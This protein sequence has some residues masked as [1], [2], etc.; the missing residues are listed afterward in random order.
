MRIRPQVTSSTQQQMQLIA[1]DAVSGNKN[2]AQA[3]FNA[4]LIQASKGAKEAASESAQVGEFRNQILQDAL[5]GDVQEPLAQLQNLEENGNLETPSKA[6]DKSSKGVGNPGPQGGNPV[7]AESALGFFASANVFGQPSLFQP[8]GVAPI[9]GSQT[10]K[11]AGTGV[12]SQR[13]AVSSQGG[14]KAA[15]AVQASVSG[16]QSGMAPVQTALFTP[17]TAKM[18]TTAS[19]L[20]ESEFSPVN[21]QGP[22]KGSTS[23][24]T[25]GSSS[26]NATGKSGVSGPKASG[27]EE[28]SAPTQR[29]AGGSGT[30]AQ[31]SGEPE[32]G[33]GPVDLSELGLTVSSGATGTP[34]DTEGQVTLKGDGTWVLPEGASAAMKAAAG[35]GNQGISQSSGVSASNQGSNGP[36]APNSSPLSPSAWVASAQFPSGN[37]SGANGAQETVS[38]SVVEPSTEAIAAGVQV[39][40][41]QQQQS[42]G[43][44][45]SLARLS[46]NGATAQSRTVSQDEGDA[47]TQGAGVSAFSAALAGATQTN[48]DA[49]G[50]DRTALS[51][52][53]VQQVA[54]A[55][56]EAQASGTPGRLVIQLKPS[57][58]GSV[59]IDLSFT[60]GKLTAHVVAAQSDVRD[61]LVRDLSSLK[62]GLESHGVQVSEVSVALRTG[63]QDQQRQGSGAQQQQ[64]QWWRTATQVAAN[65]ANAAPAGSAYGAD[66]AGGSKN[67]SALA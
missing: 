53:V 55:L 23:T 35:I 47:R 64:P 25:A 2:N 10:S 27:Q 58:L 7:S 52:P 61:V 49:S 8:M 18:L 40:E 22:V 36:T 4:A 51:E 11:G 34:V 3:K 59:Q 50:N 13:T 41:Q 16:T 9:T 28:L 21:A 46:E 15:G 56:T 39:Q 30:T 24:A 65:V 37:A 29:S 63:V 32:G 44:S 67:F 14:V 33:L 42:T 38:T 62:S 17:V 26:A 31:A 12:S 5:L 45:A 66:L 6:A 60:D 54:Q 1:A 43:A 57:N 19:D 48:A 20:G